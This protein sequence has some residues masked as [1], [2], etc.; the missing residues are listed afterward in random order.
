MGGSQKK[1]WL[2]SSLRPSTISARGP[3]PSRPVGALVSLHP[4]A[5]TAPATTT[6]IRTRI[7]AS[8]SAVDFHWGAMHFT[9]APENGADLSRDNQ[10]APNLSTLGCG[11][12]AGPARPLPA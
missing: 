4:A 12:Q 9:A 7:P 8:F 5:S 11:G 6:I 10:L 3:S 1:D 2:P